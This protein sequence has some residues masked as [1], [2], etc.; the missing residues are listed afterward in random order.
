MHRDVD[1]FICQ[2]GEGGFSREI[3]RTYQQNP[4]RTKSIGLFM[5]GKGK[6]SI[7]KPKKYIKLTSSQEVF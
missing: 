6:F 3:L 1:F 7:P 4:D 5:S 2:P